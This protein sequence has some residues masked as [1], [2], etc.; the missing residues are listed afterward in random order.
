MTCSSI[1]FT[2]PSHCYSTVTIAN[3]NNNSNNN[4]NAVKFSS[5]LLLGCQIT[6]PRTERTLMMKI[7]IKIMIRVIVIQYLL[8][9]FRDH[10]ICNQKASLTF[11]LRA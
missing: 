1:N 4:N 5:C 10:D 2:F 8:K 9:S 6:W 7:K 3:N 11:I